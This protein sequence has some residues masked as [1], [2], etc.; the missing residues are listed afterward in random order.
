MYADKM[1]PSMSAA[2]GETERR[3]VKQMA[4]NEANGITPTTIQ[5]A[6]R[7][8][9]EI[10]LRGRKAARELVGVKEEAFEIVEMIRTLEGEMIEAAE[11]LQFEKA[12]ALR[13][14]VMKLKKL[15]A[16]SAKAGGDEPVKVRRSELETPR[17]GNDKK[18]GRAGMPGVRPE[19]KSRK[20]PKN[21]E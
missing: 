2:I 14:Q 10:E 11:A 19:R 1:T 7:R 17:R 8:G 5:K 12:A 13:D 4:Y 6:I 3:R 9:M 18:K 21:P 20:K 15:R 16:E